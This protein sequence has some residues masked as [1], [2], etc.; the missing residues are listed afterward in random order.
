MFANIL[1]TLN[2]SILPSLCECDWPYYPFLLGDLRSILGIL[3]N[4]VTLSSSHSSSPG[5]RTSSKRAG[6]FLMEVFDM[7]RYF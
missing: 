2:L 7:S 1:K 3:Q 4:V 6:N 5:A